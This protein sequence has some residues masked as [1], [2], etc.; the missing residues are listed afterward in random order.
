EVLRHLGHE[1]S[2]DRR[3]DEG[4]YGVVHRVVVVVARPG[5][6][7]EV[8]S[9]AHGPDVAVVVGRSGLDGHLSADAIS[10]RLDGSHAYA[11]AV[12]RK[13]VIYLADRLGRD[14]LRRVE[15]R[16]LEDVALAVVDFQYRTVRIAHAVIG[17]DAIGAGHVEQRDFAAAED[18][19]QAVAV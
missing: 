14:D 8:R 5:S 12:V 13:D 19:G 9:V 11:G 4:G 16:L 6:H 7:D 15:R 2:P 18:Q 1:G 3:D 17:E 10:D